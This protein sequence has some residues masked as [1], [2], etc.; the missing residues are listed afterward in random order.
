MKRYGGISQK[1]LELSRAE[2]AKHGVLAPQG[3]D[4]ELRGPH[5]VSLRARYDPPRE[6]LT[7]SIVDKPFWLPAG[8]IWEI[9]DQAVG[10]F[11][12]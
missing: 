6:T 5:G 12:G 4:V 2:L 10:H 3:N 8:R 9:V 1:E 7:I 11:V